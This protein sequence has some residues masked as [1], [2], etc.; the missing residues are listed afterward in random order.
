MSSVPT[1]ELYGEFLSGLAHDP[2]HHER[3]RDRSERYGWK[4]RPHRHEK[5]AQLFVFETSGVRLRAGDLDFTTSSP[6]AL[7]VPPKI[8]HGFLFEDGTGGHVVSIPLPA[9]TED[10]AAALS[11]AP[12]RAIQP[13]DDH[14]APFT[15][16]IA[17]IGTVFAG[18]AAE[19]AM[20]LTSLAAV[21][22]AYCGLGSG[23]SPSWTTAPPETQDPRIAR[24]CEIVERGFAAPLDVAGCA[25]R[26]NVSRGHL[27]RLCQNAFGFSPGEAI[28]RRRMIEARRLLRYTQLP[29]SAIGARC[30]YPDPAYF[31]RAFRRDAG[32][33]PGQFRRVE[34]IK[35]DP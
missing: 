34:A 3:I 25:A 21:A 31:V 5:L 1:Y 20:L 7:L 29:I 26:L 13:D 22:L 15:Q 10:S 32:C 23:R 12:P 27:T 24:F 17:Q 33:S 28:T 18:Y 6:M 8:E 16:I 9:L 19:R 14:Y 35:T 30:G 11:G 4:I 2:V